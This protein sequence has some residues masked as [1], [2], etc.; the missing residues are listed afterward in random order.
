M[1]ASGQ[2][3][4]HIWRKIDGWKRR[5]PVLQGRFPTCSHKNNA[6]EEVEDNMTSSAAID[7]GNALKLFPGLA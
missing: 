6:S 3:F 4:Y 5:T 7:R 2:C 1:S